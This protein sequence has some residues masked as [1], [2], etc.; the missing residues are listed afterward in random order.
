M[1]CPD[2]E[3]LSAYADQEVSLEERRALEAHLPDCSKCR[4]QLSQ[5]G[6]VGKL[7]CPPLPAEIQINPRP[8][9]RPGWWERLRQLADSPVVHLVTTQR[10]RRSRFGAA[11]MA[12]IAGLFALP[13]M[14]MCISPD[15]SSLTAFLLF[16]ALGLMLG[17]PLRQFGEEV[18]LLA[19]LQRGRCLEEIVGTGTSA[20]GLL[21]GLAL[22]GLLQIGRAALAVWPVL[23]LG[24]LGLP[25][26][27]QVTAWQ[28]EL[29]WL[30]G[31]FGLFLSGYYFAQFLQ[32]WPGG[33]LQRILVTLLVLSPSVLLLTGLPGAFAA[34]LAIGILARRL[35]ISGLNNPVR[36]R[37]VALHK[38]NPLVRSFSQNPI[39]RR[40][41]SRLAG[42]VGGDWR[43][44][45][46]WRASMMVLPL[47]WVLHATAAPYYSW[48]DVFAIG[49][50]QFCAL[51]FVRSAMR[52]LP[53]VVRE[54]EQQSWEILLQT[55]LS[56]RSFVH[57]WLQVCLYTVF[58]EGLLAILALTGYLLALIPSDN[59]S[60]A[61]PA[62]LLLPAAS[63]LGAYVGLA[64]SAA[65][66]NARQA[67]QSL[68]LWS[69]SGLAGW[70]TVLGLVRGAIS[71]PASS[72]GLLAVYS[73]IPIGL[74]LAAR[75]RWQLRLL[76]CIDPDEGQQLLPGARYNPILLCLDLAS[77]AG[78]FYSLKTWEQLREV[79]EVSA[80]TGSSLLI[81]AALGWWLL[82]RM[83]VASLCEAA[84]GGRINLLMG[85]ILGML[86]GESL[87]MAWK[88]C[89]MEIAGFSAETTPVALQF[90]ALV[91]GI[92]LGAVAAGKLPI[93]EIRV[94]ILVARLRWTALT[95]LTGVA[96]SLWVWS[97]KL[98]QQPTS[99]PPPARRGYAQ[100]LS[101]LYALLPHPELNPSALLVLDEQLPQLGAPQAQDDDHGAGARRY[102]DLLSMV[103]K[104][105][106]R[107]ENWPRTLNTLRWCL[108][109][110]AVSPGY[111]SDGR[112]FKQ[113]FPIFEDLREC[114]NRA[115]LDP[116]QARGLIG[117]LMDLHSL[118]NE[119]R[120]I[121]AEYLDPFQAL[122]YAPGLPKWY[123]ERERAALSLAKARADQ[124][125]AEGKIRYL[126][127]H[128]NE[129]LLSDVRYCELTKRQLHNPGLSSMVQSAAREG[130]W[131]EGLALLVAIKLYRLEHASQWPDNLGQVQSY[132]PRP[133]HCYTRADD[134]FT[135]RPGFL[136]DGEHSQNLFTEEQIK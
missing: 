123:L 135:Y 125:I 87:Q 37:A 1:S 126:T 93:S 73:L 44:L 90:G 55:R 25:L 84:L 53:A 107:R 8:R 3:L 86:L 92:V 11:Q 76:P 50:V 108:M 91:L 70:L 109:C 36:P 105:Q 85:G 114:L 83:P 127:E 17:L 103:A 75:A 89:P 106:A 16:S 33:G 47:A 34:A 15:R 54:R 10:Q 81:A 111:L 20:Q 38:R 122:G 43:R 97:L 6:L 26:Q 62:L 119:L 7:V 23:L 118:Q 58:S 13:A 94:P 21:D 104:Q 31:L 39:A 95:L 65:S 132:L 80:A 2:F 102:I 40:E 71:R 88:L 28:L 19:S 63:L 5:L 100:Q 117:Q 68:M 99:S 46:A 121:Y 112:Y 35:A 78:L 29:L 124:L 41:M 56:L 14:F 49:T 48:P 57:G 45:M 30:P 116:A 52:T 64:I 27:W 130:T 9:T 60:V 42:Q 72:W 101:Q 51:F 12:K 61:G 120:G 22:Q 18:A 136:A 115:P 113:E 98:P 32:V 82:V 134:Q 74:V 96:A 69:L 131:R 77:L 79:A 59:W 66:R 110:Q 133:V 24:T 129:E 67:S 4:N 128:G